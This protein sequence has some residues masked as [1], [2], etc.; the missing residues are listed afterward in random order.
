MT[1]SRNLAAFA[2]LNGALAVLIGAFAAHG[3][4]PQVKTLLTTAAVVAASMA[5]FSAPASAGGSVSSTCGA[6]RC[7]FN[8]TILNGLTWN[9][10]SLQ[11]ISLQGISL[12]GISLQ[13][14]QLNGPGLILQGTASTGWVEAQDSAPI[15]VRLASGKIIRLR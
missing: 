5:A 11:G 1:V 15:A 6:W 13:G 7:G 12:Q 3:A 10:I 8:G 14:V 4:E 9:G 2:A